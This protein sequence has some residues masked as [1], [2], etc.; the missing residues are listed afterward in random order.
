MIELEIETALRHT[1][2]TMMKIDVQLISALLNA[3]LP[4]WS[5]LPIEALSSEGTDNA[6]FRIGS[7]L[8]ARL[9]KVEWAA[10]QPAREHQWLSFLASK[11][12]L[13]IPASIVLG[14][15]GF[16]YPWHWSVHSWSSGKSATRVDLENPAAAERLAGFLAAMRAINASG[17]PE[18]GAENSQR[19]VPLTERDA[20]VRRALEELHDEPG[21][22]AAT[23]VWDDA[24]SAPACCSEPV[25]LHGDLQ[26]TNL[27]MRH[28]QLAAVID[29][30]LMGVGDPA[31]D[32]MA[33]WTCFGRVSRRIFLSATKADEATVRRGRGWAVSTALIALAYYRHT[34]PVMAQTSRSTMAEV[35]CDFKLR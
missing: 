16:G 33:G 34:N 30:G 14:L 3:Q 27:I 15:P 17:G 19:G 11:L 13:E 31:C 23:A 22:A 1:V 7:D 26:P 4:A 12:P 24:L 2:T 8:V 32:L 5:D 29:F 20:S 18:S 6:V 21:I 10:G 28:G 35:V 25:W 9:P